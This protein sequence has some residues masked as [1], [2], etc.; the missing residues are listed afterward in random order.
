MI[1]SIWEFCP[2]GDGYSATVKSWSYRNK[3]LD[4]EQMKHDL[5]S[6]GRGED[7]NATTAE[8]V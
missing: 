6:Q 2:E 3:K 5:A 7:V 1:Y 8:K 4:D